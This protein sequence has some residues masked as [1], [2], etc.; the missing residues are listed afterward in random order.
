MHVHYTKQ[1]S[2]PGLTL[3]VVC[4]A[5]EQRLCAA[6]VARRKDALLGRVKDDKRKLRASKGRAKEVGQGGMRKRC[7]RER[8]HA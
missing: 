1:G 6:G 8:A 3:T 2:G 4:Q 5:I 7:A